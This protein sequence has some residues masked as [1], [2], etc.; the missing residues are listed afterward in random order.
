MRFIAVLF[1]LLPLIEIATFI[2]VGQA[3]GLW[4]TLLGV[5]MTGLV[6][7]LVLRWQGFALLG[8]MRA[9]MARGELPGRTIADAMMIGL[10]GFLLLVPGYFTD[11]LGIL[12]LLPPVRSGI[13]GLLRSRMRVVPVTTTTYHWQSGPADP[14]QIDNDTIELGDDAYRPRQD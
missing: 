2:V 8:Q 5:V 3:I 13:Y 7:A 11:V 9:T 4:A 6:G 14:R 12:L 10:G 1:L